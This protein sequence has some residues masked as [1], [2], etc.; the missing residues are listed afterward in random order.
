[1]NRIQ[2]KQR[3]RQ[4]RSMRRRILRDETRRGQRDLVQRRRYNDALLAGGEG[5]MGAHYEVN[6]SSEEG[7]VVRTSI[8]AFDNLEFTKEYLTWFELQSN[9]KLN[10]KICKLHKV[11]IQKD[12]EEWIDVTNRDEMNKFVKEQEGSSGRESPSQVAAAFE[13]SGRPRLALVLPPKYTV[14]AVLERYDKDALLMMNQITEMKEEEDR[15]R[16][17]SQLLQQWLDCT[18]AFD[19]AGWSIIDNKVENVLVNYDESTKTITKCVITDFESIVK[20]S[21]QLPF[22]I[23]FTL[24]IGGQPPNTPTRRHIVPWLGLLRAAC[25][26]ALGHDSL[27]PD[28]LQNESTLQ[29]N[30]EEYTRSAQDIA[31]TDLQV[32]TLKIINKV[33]DGLPQEEST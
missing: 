12:E 24:S 23:G 2:H 9:D 30:V 4:L 3:V 22:N 5:A 32:I 8:V 1:M 21:D 17:S 16:V 18:E 33:A 29:T 20:Q 19:Q 7:K 10:D 13:S 28:V 31:H 26:L 15:H 14:Q 27:T 25:I 6:P 11:S